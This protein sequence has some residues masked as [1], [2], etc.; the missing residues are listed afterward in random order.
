MVV[1][2]PE[3]GRGDTAGQG[4]SEAGVTCSIFLYSEHGNLPVGHE[5][6]MKG[7]KAGE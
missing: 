4:G 1:G 7:F 5:Q 3:L 6:P 2:R